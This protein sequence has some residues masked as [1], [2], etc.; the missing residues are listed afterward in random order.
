[1]FPEKGE[2]KWGKNANGNDQNEV[3]NLNEPSTVPSSVEP[4]LV[5]PSARLT[6]RDP[7]AKQAISAGALVISS[8]CL[9]KPKLFRPAT[10]FHFFRLQKAEKT[11]A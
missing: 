1:M 2:E 6:A 5:A 7:A 11:A 10:E 9:P 3:M 4:R 8:N